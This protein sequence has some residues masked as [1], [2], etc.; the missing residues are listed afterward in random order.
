MD[1]GPVC[2]DVSNVDIRAS[3]KFIHI[4]NFPSLKSI[5]NITGFKPVI[6]SYIFR[7]KCKNIYKVPAHS[8]MDIMNFCSVNFQ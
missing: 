2:G 1:W 8:L 6:S 5:Y 3:F 7:C 4:F